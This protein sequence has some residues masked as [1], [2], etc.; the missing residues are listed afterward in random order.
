MLLNTLLQMKKENSF[1]FRLKGIKIGYLSIIM[2]FS[3]HNI[4]SPTYYYFVLDYTLSPPLPSLL[5]YLTYASAHRW[6]PSNR[7]DAVCLGTA[8]GELPSVVTSGSDS[9][10]Q[11]PKLRGVVVVVKW[12]KK[13]G[14]FILYLFHSVCVNH[15][16]YPSGERALAIKEQK[17]SRRGR[18]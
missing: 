6:V 10:R 8:A 2:L 14:G 9:Q 4:V 17:N 5:P 16:V 12:E 18:R 13:K 11:R 15:E 7:C 3:Y 1:N